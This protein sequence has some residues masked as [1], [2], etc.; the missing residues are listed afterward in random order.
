M[1]CNLNFLQRTLVLFSRLSP[2]HISSPYLEA[3]KAVYLNYVFALF[4]WVTRH[5][6]LAAL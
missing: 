1:A 5:V 4:F 6:F 3:F 2:G